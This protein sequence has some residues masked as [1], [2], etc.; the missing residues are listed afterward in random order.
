M[1][2]YVATSPILS[3]QIFGHL[4]DVATLLWLYATERKSCDELAMHSS[5]TMALCNRPLAC[6][7]LRTGRREKIEFFLELIW[8]DLQ[9][10]S[11]AVYST[12]YNHNVVSELPT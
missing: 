10:D 9:R 7:I 8:N 6:A 5:L 12:M 2:Y 11:N 1:P 4:L 3:S